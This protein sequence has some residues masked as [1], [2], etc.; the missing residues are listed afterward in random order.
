VTEPGTRPTGGEAVSERAG[1]PA[2]PPTDIA[3]M[4]FDRALTELQSVVGRLEA[5]GLALEDSID[6]YERGVALHDHCSTLLS[7]A[8][9]RVQRLVDQAGGRLRAVDL[10]VDDEP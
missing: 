8:E 4:P 7:G 1:T 3:A 5:G 9:L 10:G 2:P 6:L